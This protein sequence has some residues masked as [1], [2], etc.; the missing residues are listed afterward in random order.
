MADEQTPWP[1]PP[2]EPGPWGGGPPVAPPGNTPL[3]PLPGA[4]GT[5]HTGAAS[6]NPFA[7]AGTPPNVPPPPP[8]P[9]SNPFPGLPG[10]PRLVDRAP[11]W[12]LAL[13]ALVVLAMVAGGAYVVIEG[14]PSFPKHW[15]P[16]V[17]AIADWVQ[18]DRGLTY[19]HPIKV[20]FLT[21]AEYT[22][23][24]V[25]D[26]DGSGS[27]SKE[28]AQQAK[29][30]AAQLRALGLLA[31]DPDL[32][33]ASDTL[34]DSGTLAFYSPDSK[35][36]YIRG[37]VKTAAD[38]TP[39]LRVTLAHELTHVLQDQYFDL[40]RMQ[41]LPDGQAT[42]MRALAEGDATRIEE[43]YRTKVLSATERSA[44]DKQ[45]QADSDKGEAKLDKEVPAILN[46]FFSAPYILGPELVKYLKADGG[47]AKIDAALKDPPGEEVLFDPLTYGTPAAKLQDVS[48]SAPSG[49]KAIDSGDFG[50]T[51]WYLVLA[52]RMD[53][54]VALKAV[55]GWGGDH[56][57]TYRESGRVCQLSDA[58][59]DTPAD[60]TEFRAALGT[61]VA[62]SPK[63][64]AS[65]TD[66]GKVVE[67]KSCDPGKDA[68]L[69]GNAASADLLDVPASR[70]EIYAE[71]VGEPGLDST[72]AGCFANAF[73]QRFTL[74]QLNDEKY[75][76]TPAAQQ[77]IAQIRQT[78]L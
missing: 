28:S 50:P 37:A 44:Y 10:G 1:S 23:A 18:T 15:D 13:S 32:N 21:P 72:K 6:T 52:S 2:R 59:F 61:W 74:D 56:Y 24:S 60:R 16:R 38:M 3:P 34:Q 27:D 31:G 64:A 45:S 47:S 54:R 26:P 42:T 78:C 8:Q 75:L 29:D 58:T 68:K 71:V 46:T 73:V 11:A 39:S 63:G 66:K 5:M 70:T 41:K 33:K 25:G 48:V 17:Q 67:L 53:P 35:E 14:G 62:Q 7:A 22:K 69:P 30:E 4:S 40:N 9:R 20:E 43:D 76:G 57:V 51:A 77:Q 49:Q 19:K 55:D 12:V 65:I 36:V